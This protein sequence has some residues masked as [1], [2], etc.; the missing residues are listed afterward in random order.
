MNTFTQTTLNLTLAPPQI[1][2]KVQFI[3]LN[4][5]ALCS[6]YISIDEMQLI[7]NKLRFI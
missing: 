4:Q 5:I 2:L 6:I 3:P 7:H 1:A